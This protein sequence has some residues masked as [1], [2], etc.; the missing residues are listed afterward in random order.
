MPYPELKGLLTDIGTEELGHLEMIGA[1]VHQLT[2]DMTID[3]ILVFLPQATDR[4]RKLSAMLSRPAKLRAEDTG[5]TSIIEYEYL[6]Y[7]LAAVQKDYD[8]LMEKKTKLMTALDL[9]NN[10]VPFDVE[11]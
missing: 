1:V 10:T 5:R 11:L 8:A 3:E 7:D 4:L 9:T 2:R 6:N